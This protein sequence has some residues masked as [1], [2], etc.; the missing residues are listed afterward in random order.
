MQI[1]GC[2]TWHVRIYWQ[3]KIMVCEEDIPLLENPNSSW[4]DVCNLLLQEVA[5]FSK[6]KKHI[7]P[8]R[9]SQRWLSLVAWG[10]LLLWSLYQRPSVPMIHINR[11]SALWQIYLNWIISMWWILRANNWYNLRYFPFQ[12]LLS[13]HALHNSRCVISCESRV[14][15]I[16]TNI[17][18]AYTHWT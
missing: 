6:N 9:K 1:I 14:T 16:L 3:D 18:K 13:G 11:V 8:W 17:G 10:F 4:T 5:T 2:C 12:L 7:A 15:H